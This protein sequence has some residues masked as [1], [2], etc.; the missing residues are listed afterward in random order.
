[1]TGI[2]VIQRETVAFQD[3]GADEQLVLVEE[4]VHPDGELIERTTKVAKLDDGGLK[5]T[6][7]DQTFE[8]VYLGEEAKAAVLAYLGGD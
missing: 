7:S 3:D 6:Q 8:Q 1:M 4:Y 5:V 2:D